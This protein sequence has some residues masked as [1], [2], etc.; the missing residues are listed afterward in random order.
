M[1]KRKSYNPY[2]R[3]KVKLSLKVG[4]YELE[5]VNFKFAEKAQ[6]EGKKAEIESILAAALNREIDT[7]SLGN[8]HFRSEDLYGYKITT[9]DPDPVPEVDEDEDDD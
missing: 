7:F 3:V 2:Y 5:R 6:A 9:K 4:G 8:S 1:S